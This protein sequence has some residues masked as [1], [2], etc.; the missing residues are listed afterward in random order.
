M[1]YAIANTLTTGEERRFG[2]VGFALGRK[3]LPFGD[4]YADQPIAGFA[5]TT[6]FHSDRDSYASFYGGT[7]SPVKI[8][9]GR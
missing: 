4:F 6:I 1:W 5:E 7:C 3:L 2:W 9:G 8:Q